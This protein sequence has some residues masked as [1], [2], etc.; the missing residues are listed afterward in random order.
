MFKIIL[1]LATFAA[2]LNA[3]KNKPSTAGSNAEN[4]ASAASPDT[5]QMDGTNA[6]AGSQTTAQYNDAV[7]KLKSQAIQETDYYGRV[8]ASIVPLQ[9]ELTRAQ[10][11]IP[12]LGKVTVSVDEHF[13][14]LIKNEKGKDVLEKKAPLKD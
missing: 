3:C 6:P 5:V 10:G 12:S 7:E 13:N 8:Q 4:I 1:F 14:L 2:L 11:K 9:E